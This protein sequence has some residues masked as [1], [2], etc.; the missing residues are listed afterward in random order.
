VEFPTE[1]AAARR[2]IGRSGEREAATSIEGIMKRLMLLA[3]LALAPTAANAQDNIRLLGEVRLR[4]E[5]ERPAP[6]DSLDALTLL[7]ARL[8]V[9]ASLSERAHVF[10]QVQD[11][12]TF[13]EEETTADG[14]ADR[15][16]VH[17]AWLQYGR[18]LGSYAWSVRAGR[19]EI[20]L[21]NERLMGAVGWSNTGRSFD[22]ARLTV[23]PRTGTAWSVSTL[24]ATVRERGRR[25]T[26]DTPERDDHVLLG[27]FAD[28]K[29][30]E[31]FVLHDH[32]A[33][34]RQA[35]GV[36]RTTLGA[37]LT[38]PDFARLTTSVEAAYQIGNQV[39]DI[40]TDPVSQDIRAW[41]LGA[42]LSYV[43][44]LAVLP[45]IGVGI[46]YLSGD[47]S[48]T[49]GTYRAFNTLYATNHKYYGYIDYFLDPAART[50]DRG[51]VDG[52]ASVAVALPRDLRL[53]LDGHAFWTEQ[54]LAPDAER[55]IGWELDV[56][57]PVRLGP[58][59]QLQL[60]Y[61]AFRNGPA[62]PLIGLGRERAWSHWAY[63]Q[64]TFS[65]GGALTPLL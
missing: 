27:M 20:I 8:G 54:P 60:G 2:Q 14:T 48:P 34:Y 35:E 59:Q 58:G 61:S 62:A 29:P 32:E 44:P 6:T 24:A 51:L 17:Q 19:Q 9:Q 7:R 43:P 40:S 36:D 37:R 28:V 33:A 30:V 41:L 39:W 65:F 42:R 23:G 50:Q 52:I 21:G 31:L 49:D 63:L 11:A 56:T 13:G 4:G 64:A 18:E 46:D 12:R 10:M 53:E 16:D 45:R 5:A 38:P 25:F 1:E 26:G 55:L 22:G 47:E 3:V 57:L 15:L